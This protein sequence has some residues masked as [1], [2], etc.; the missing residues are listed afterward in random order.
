MCLAACQNCVPLGWICD[1][2]LG[3]DAEEGVG[4][5]KQKQKTTSSN[6]SYLS[7]TQRTPANKTAAVLERSRQAQD[8]LRCERFLTHT[9]TQSY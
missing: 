3:C 1:P 9:N 2:N 5:K 8:H 6:A 7:E 4:N